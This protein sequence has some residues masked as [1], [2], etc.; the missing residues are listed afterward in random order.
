MELFLI[1]APPPM[2]GPA[3]SE[4][5]DVPSDAD[6]LAATAA[7]R[8]GSFDPFVQRYKQRMF[9][10]L[11]R[12]T[13]DHHL[14]EDLLQEVFVKAFSAARAGRYDGRAVA[15]GWLFAIAHRCFIDAVRAK[16]AS[17]RPIEDAGHVTDSTTG[18]AAAAL[19]DHHRRI[20]GALATIPDEQREVLTLRIFGELSFAQIADATGQA[21]PTI[22]SRMRYA[23]EKVR[24]ILQKG[25]DSDERPDHPG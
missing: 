13:A 11:Y 23:L 7:G 21:L 20:R 15:A 3:M 9:N 2:T 24:A 17:A 12:Q 4:V 18:P 16:Q 6:L 1:E 8:V 19:A 25:G 22:K 10:F 14:A 5:D